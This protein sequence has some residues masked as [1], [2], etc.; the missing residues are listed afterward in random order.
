MEFYRETDEAVLEEL[1]TDHNG[2]PP[3][4]A[5]NR[6]ERDGFNEIQDKA[7]VSTWKLFIETFKD[8]MVLVLL[9]A[10]LIQIVL[11][12]VVESIIIFLVLLLNAVISVVQTKKAEGSIAALRSLSAPEAQI[13]RAG[14]RQKV[15]ARELVVGDIVFLEAGDYVPADGR[16]L[17]S[18]SLK[19][20]EGMLTGESEA[21]NKHTEQISEESA[22]GD[23]LNMVFSSSLVVHGRG[24]FVATGTG[25]HSE[26]G[27]IATM[28]ESA[29]EKSTPLQ[30]KLDT[31]SKK[32]GI[33]ILL[34]S[35]AIFVVQIGRIWLNGDTADMTTSVLNALMFSVAVAVAAVPEALSSI[36]T[37][38]LSVGTNK[39]A[40]ENAI[41]RKLPA[42][43][44]LGSTSI[45]C[46]DKTGTL[47]QN[48]MTVTEYFIP[49]QEEKDFPE[50]PGVWNEQERMLIDIMTLC[51][52]SYINQDEQEIGDPTEVAL[53]QFAA[54]QNEDYEALR[55]KHERIAELP[56]D[57]E[58]KLMSTVHLVRDKQMMFTKGGPDVVFS[59]AS[60]VLLNGEEVV[61]TAEMKEQFV[62]QYEM[63]S[64]RALR[65]IAYAYKRL[66]VE[67]KQIDFTDEYDLVLVGMTA[68]IDPPREA[69]YGA[70]RDAKSAG[71]RTIMITGDHK[72]T[73]Q[74]IAREIGIIEE[75][76]MAIS[77]QELDE[78]A[79]TEL[80][81]KLPS[82]SVYARVSP[83]NKIR[84]V[85]AW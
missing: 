31:F 81:E 72:T 50:D 83:E 43:E 64:D 37:I 73:A 57:S 66:S 71:I 46:T 11:G 58:R 62:N 7:H 44:T 49:E 42:V 61:L 29:G 40:K 59:R 28:L 32:L 54:K 8:P 19:I 80:D 69:V 84:I 79:E 5:K 30:Q 68:M 41:I 20:N 27:K 14:T 76:D 48:K 82:I 67:R 45:I 70:V 55:A 78:M 15:P 34:L 65:G 47:T 12:E 17:E 1:K 63:F 3:K 35:V 9:A 10:A 21:V 85:R 77:G 26:I 51:N 56:F 23:R 60:H 16:I 75:Q 36:V 39:M 24:T 52:D 33:V 38:V 6:L 25:E 4:E 18:G 2:V 74:A 22:L 53:I 13:I